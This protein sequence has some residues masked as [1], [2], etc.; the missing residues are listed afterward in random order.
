MADKKEKSLKWLLLH[1]L[2]YELVILVLSIPI[3]KYK[4]IIPLI[5]SGICHLIIDLVKYVILKILS[6][7]YLHTDIIDRNAYFTD[8]ILHI[9]TLLFIAYWIK[10]IEIVVSDFV[11]DFIYTLRIQDNIIL[12]VLSLLIIN[13][14]ANITI[15]KLLIKYKPEKKENQKR[16]KNAGRL[17][18]TV[19]RIIML[20]L[21]SIGQYSAIGLVLTAKS[22]ARY[23]RIAKEEDF[24][25]YYLLGTLLSTLIVI[26]CS[27]LVK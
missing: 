26:L 6:R 13:K 10:D 18:G 24:A 14:P 9:I 16:D 22:I 11:M 17:I 12:W 4:L 20:I 2:C 8:Q 5:L 3:F 7:K 27:F 19:E 25:E 15:Q 21:I 23:D 1:S